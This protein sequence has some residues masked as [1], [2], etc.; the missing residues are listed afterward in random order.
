MTS[1]TQSTLNKE[2][3][4]RAKGLVNTSVDDMQSGLWFYKS[5]DDLQL[6]RTALMITNKRGEKTK[7]RILK[8]K[9]KKLEKSLGEG[10]Q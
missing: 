9:I 5:R 10:V 8:S 2:L 6:L 4:E 1:G 7:S 3:A